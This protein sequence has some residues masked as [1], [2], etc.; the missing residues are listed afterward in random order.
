MA[1]SEESRVPQDSEP[2]EYQLPPVLELL[3]GRRSQGR[4]G[5]G[6]SIDAIVEAAVRLADAEGLAGVSMSKVAAELGFTTMSLYRHVS[7]KD[8]LLALMWN[9]S[10]ADAPK[11]AGDGWRERL[12]GWALAQM[13]GLQAHPWILDLPIGS[14]PA[15]PNSLQWVEQA[16]ASFEN[17]VLAE[18]EKLAAVGLVTSYVLGEARMSKDEA[19]AIRA[20]GDQAPV[21]FPALL[22]TFAAEDT[23]PALHRAVASGEFDD[24]FAPPATWRDNPGFR[25]G[26]DRI[27]DGIEVLMDERQGG[28][29]PGPGRS[30]AGVSPAR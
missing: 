27:L 18:R 24:A 20:G 7:G 11:I 19:A 14:P 8:E 22:R 9:A 23:Y 21:D 3:W 25:F 4:R 29:Q 15:G 1:T 12:E 16:I 10:A 5:G 28:D 2:S 17:T 13:D 30:S 6:L 26:L